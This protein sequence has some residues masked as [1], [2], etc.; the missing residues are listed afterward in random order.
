MTETREASGSRLSLRPFFLI[1]SGQAVSLLGSQVAQFALIW[2]LT[3]ETGSGTVL[4]A[5]TFLG[6]V[7]Q[8]VLG[9]LA[10]ALID[11]WNRQRIL[12]VADGVIALVSLGLAVLFW[13]DAASTW[14]VLAALLIRAVASAFHQ[15]TMAAS[16]SLMVPKEHLTRVQGA[17]ETLEGVLLIASAPLGALLLGVAPISAILGLDVLTA[18]FALAPLFVISVPQPGRS[19]EPDEQ[20]S[21]GADVIAGLRYVGAWPG[22]LIVVTMGALIN[23]FTVPASAL[24]PLLVREHF[25]GGAM[26][27]GGMTLAFGVGL[28]AGGATL[29]IWGGFRRRVVTSLCGLLG[30]AVALLAIGLAPA[31]TY[32]LA[33]AGFFAAGAMATL[34]NG[35]L[36]AVLQA[37][38]AP[39]LQGRVFTL[40]TTLAVAASLVGLAISGPLADLVGPRTWYVMGAAACA[41]MGLSGF[42]VPAVLHIEERQ[43]DRMSSELTESLGET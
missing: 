7:P 5:A 16:T 18:A 20:P 4:A 37:V 24:L 38:V 12:I 34:V 25:G 2:W 26:Q 43:P 14:H 3:L 27:F 11:R 31:S 17:N 13:R 41:V 28:I 19:A 23:F 42:A 22:L 9:P 33:V 40:V 21:I 6:L 8:V 30:L 39:E 15:P 35:P 10:G 36:Q 29:G 32:S 1:W